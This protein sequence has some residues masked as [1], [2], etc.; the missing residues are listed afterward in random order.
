MSEKNILEVRHLSVCYKNVMAVEDVSFEV[1][2]NEVFGIIGPNGAGKTSL[3]EAIEGLRDFLSGEVSVLGM[4]P[5]TDRAGLHEKIGVQLQQTSYSDSAKVLDVC[6]LFASFYDRAAS[7][8]SLLADM[9]LDKKKDMYINK[10]SSGQRQ[11]LSILLSLL[12]SPK[13]VFWD[14]LTT[15][16]DPLARHEVWNMIRQYKKVGLTIVLISH[17]MDEIESLCDRV[18]LMK[19]GKMIYIGTPEEVIENYG[20]KNLDDVFLKLNDF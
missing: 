4:N 11:K 16:L 17:F 14:E 13:I 12:G 18:A 9:G 10:L 7:Y 19:S 8:D 6:K 2:E 20:A 1:K 15:G 3:V 5:K